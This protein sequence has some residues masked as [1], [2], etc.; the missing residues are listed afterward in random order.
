M[1]DR[2]IDRYLLGLRFHLRPLNGG[3]SALLEDKLF[4]CSCSCSK[5]I[6]KAMD[7]MYVMCEATQR[8]GDSLHPEVLSQL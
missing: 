6:I 1:T 4:E 5:V 2:G 3:S 7:E 8:E